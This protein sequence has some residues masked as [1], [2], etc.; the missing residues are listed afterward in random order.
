[1]DFV[2]VD[3]A[4]FATYAEQDKRQPLNW[5]HAR[6]A[7]KL[8][9]FEAKVARTVDASL[10]VSEAEAALFCR[11]SGLGTD[12]VHAV[13]NGIDTERFDPVLALCAGRGRALVSGTT[14]LEPAQRDALAEAAQRIPLLW[15]SNFS[16]GVA[17]SW[18]D[19]G[20]SSDWFTS[21]F[22][23]RSPALTE[24]ASSSCTSG[25]YAGLAGN[26]VQSAFAVVATNTTRPW[27]RSCTVMAGSRRPFS[28][29]L[30]SRTRWAFDP[31]GSSTCQ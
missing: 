8:G 17:V 14:G 30:K 9:A 7:R 23:Q 26:V 6:E 5:V 13:E 24:P 27:P 15:A 1:M 18:T 19:G 25:R 22:N 11:Q 20:I 21:R 2:D 10:F 4:K 31:G 3:S 28:S 29:G 16:V 12:T